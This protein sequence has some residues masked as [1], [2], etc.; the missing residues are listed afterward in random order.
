MPLATG[1]DK[2]NAAVCSWFVTFTAADIVLRTFPHLEI[3]KDSPQ[4]SAYHAR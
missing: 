3:T 2:P 1:L 4:R